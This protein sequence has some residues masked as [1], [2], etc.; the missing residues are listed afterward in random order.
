MIWKTNFYEVDSPNNSKG[1]DVSG[2]K[3]YHPLITVL[4]LQMACKCSASKT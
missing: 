1:L 4:Y 3:H 2:I